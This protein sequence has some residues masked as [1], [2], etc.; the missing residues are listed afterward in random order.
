MPGRQHSEPARDTA[1]GASGAQPGAQYEIGSAMG[2]TATSLH[3]LSAVGSSGPRL[4][5]DIE[6][7]YRKLGYT[8]PKKAGAA[9]A[10]RVILA[11][12][13][14]GDWLSIYDW[15]NDRIDTGELKQL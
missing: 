6:K 14:S 11:P 2:T 5:E 1:P 3:V 7:A 4:Q 13:A 10:K 8:R 9:V 15:D 12:D